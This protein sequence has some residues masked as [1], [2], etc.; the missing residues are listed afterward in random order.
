MKKITIT[1]LTACLLLA[2][3]PFAATASIMIPAATATEMPS[4]SAR[5]R[6]MAERFMEIK[7]MDKSELSAGERKALRKEQREL[8]RS[9]GG[10]RRGGIYLSIGAIII[11]VLLL[12]LIL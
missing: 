12:I 4:D 3:N 5:T 7:Q 11:I 9:I 6:A 10:E 8:K 2:I 1:F